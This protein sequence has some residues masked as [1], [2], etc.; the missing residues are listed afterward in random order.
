MRSVPN[1]DT[2]AQV[3]IRRRVAAIATSPWALTA[4]VALVA[5]VVLWLIVRP[6]AGAVNDTDAAASVL[7]FERI[8]HGQRLEAF[9]PTTPKPLLTVVYGIAWNITGDWRALTLLTI[10]VGAAA[11][12]LAARLAARLG[13]VA[14]AAI[15][16]VGFLAWPDF[17]LE[18]ARANSLVWGLALW[19]LAGVLMT[20]AKPR[21]WMAGIALMLAGLVRTETIWLLAAAC[22]Y[23]AWTAWRALRR[24][25]FS[26]LRLSYPLLLGALAIPLACL[27]DLVLTG[28][29]LYWLSVP[30]GYTALVYPGLQ[31]LSVVES[32]RKELVYYEPAALLLV[33]AFA[34]LV[35]LTMSRWAAVA[36]A[37]VSLT[38]GVLLT[39]VVLSWRGVFISIRYYEEA[40]APIL[41]AAAIAGGVLIAT[42]L[43]RIP[44]RSATWPR[45][46]VLATPAVAA[47]LALGVVAADVPLGTVEPQTGSSREAYAALEAHIADVKA[48]V[49]A[50]SGETL[51]VPGVGYPVA[52]SEAGR[53]YVPRPLLPAISVQ[54]GAPIVALGDSY[55][56]FRGGSYALRP[57][58]WVLHIAA[59]DG[60]RGVYEPFEHSAPTTLLASDGRVVTVVPVVA[61]PADGL[62]LDRIDAAPAA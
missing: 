35:W 7:Y 34:G 4:L 18:V 39:L 21:P 26:R 44:V 19:L 28:R 32:V 33:L 25:E 3:G 5:A 46:R 60:S 41:L 40:N 50:T 56:G 57:G 23:V 38:G 53:M 14:S 30:G 20:A 58:Q 15:V 22:V 43:D 52:D 42:I 11:V 8:V 13:G 47:A 31:S 24:G 45:W 49:L 6:L 59:A 37:F 54:T 61:D 29:P 27:H 36:L 2:R 16:V 55:L 51:T 48:V 1:G 12:G 17:G 10:A 9:V 62:W